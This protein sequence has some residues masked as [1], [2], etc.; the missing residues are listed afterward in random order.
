MMKVLK[1]E[2]LSITETEIKNTLEALQAAVDGFIEAVTLVQDRAVMLVNE[3]G[4]LRDLPLN[5][6]ASAVANTQIVGTAIVVG[7]DGEEFTD[8]PEDV[9]RCIKAL[10]A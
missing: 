9:E 2:G 1:L 8:I 10:F 5:P 7:V 3:E 4:L 6:V